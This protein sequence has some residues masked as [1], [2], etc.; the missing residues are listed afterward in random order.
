LEGQ[1]VQASSTR[2]PFHDVVLSA[3]AAFSKRSWPYVVALVVPWLLLAGQRCMTRMAAIAP[4]RRSESAYY[5]FLSG[6]KWRLPVLFRSLFELVTRTFKSPSLTLAIDDTLVPKVG[7]GIFGT[8][9]HH[10]HVSRPRAGAIW[11]H[12]WFVLAVVVQ[13]GSIAWI[14]LPVWVSLYRAKKS[15][16]PKEFRS[17]TQLALEALRAVRTWCSGRIVLLADGAYNHNG[18]IQTLDEL[19]IHLV[20]RLRSNSD[21]CEP[22]PPPPRA[23]KR[24]RKPRH[25]ARISLRKRLAQSSR[26]VPLEVEIY[27]KKV[28]LLAH[29]FVAWWGAANRVIKV[30]ITKDPRH[31]GRVAFLSSTD[32]TLSATDVIELFARRWSI[33]QLFSV[34]KNQLGFGSSEVRTANSVTRHAALTMAL[35]T[36]VE[37]WAWRKN[38]RTAAA[39]FATKL[40][41]LREQTVASLVF[42]SGPRTR[43]QGRISRSL[44]GLFAT[45]TRAA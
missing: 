1:A 32:T 6:G 37:V 45:A 44:A 23:G 11:G 27:G 24:G 22:T 7:R 42:A 3:R 35:A 20:S 33:E 5:R 41:C 31:P 15:C 34:C 8:G 39:S 26:F 28:R 17:R 10:D 4:R 25:G 18:L 21:L 30:V 13:V 38:P 36:W 14:A 2:S 43:A 19:G 40:T 16:P 9:Y 29:E 12:N